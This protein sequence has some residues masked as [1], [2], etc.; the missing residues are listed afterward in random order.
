MSAPAG[1]IL[2]SSYFDG[3]SSL[4][5]GCAYIGS[6]IVATGMVFQTV[7]SRPDAGAFIWMLAKVFI[8]GVS[9]LFIREWLMR[10]NDIVTAF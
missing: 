9:I 8:I 10:L 5:G 6:A 3:L 2:P 4:W 7:R 1:S